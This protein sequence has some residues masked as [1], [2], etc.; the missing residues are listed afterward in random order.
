MD[1]SVLN[2]T[3]LLRSI[4]K[5][6]DK[7][8]P[9]VARELRSIESMQKKID[10]IDQQTRNNEVPQSLRFKFQ[11]SF[12]ERIQRTAADTEL[13]Q[14]ASLQADALLNDTKCKL[15]AAIRS[16]HIRSVQAAK[17]DLKM[18]LQNAEQEIVDFIYEV[19]KDMKPGYCQPFQDIM[20]VYFC[21]SQEDQTIDPAL[22][23]CL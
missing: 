5:I 17:E 22:P 9:L 15:R 21:N 23:N 19:V 6:V 16:I 12:P 11:L 18:A 14:A 3:Q 2:S 10:I 1:D 4:Q 7:N 13:N 8:L 20:R